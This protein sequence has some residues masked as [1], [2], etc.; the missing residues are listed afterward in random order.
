MVNLWAVFIATVAAVPMNASS[1]TKSGINA[2]P[3]VGSFKTD[4]QPEKAER[5]AVVDP[6][7][8]L[9]R[10]L[11]LSSN[12]GA[13][14][15]L[16]NKDGLVRVDPKFPGNDDHSAEDPLPSHGGLSMQPTFTTTRNE[17]PPSWFKLAVWDIS[18]EN[19]MNY[20]GLDDEEDEQDVVH[21]H[22]NTQQ[23]PTKPVGPDGQVEGEDDVN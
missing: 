21:L 2:L 3:T 1:S 14:H 10:K 7:T 4:S 15:Y 13:K 18:K 16:V 17:P 12:E 20:D 23:V 9:M 8:G 5:P 6:A 11:N 19:N 22:Q